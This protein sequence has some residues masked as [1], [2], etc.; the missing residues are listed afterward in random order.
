MEL[1][2]ALQALAQVDNRK[3]RV[4]EL[5]FFGG[6]SVDE[7]AEALGSLR[8]RSTVTGDWRSRGF[9]ASSEGGRQMDPERWS[10]IDRIYHEAASLTM[11]SAGVPYRDVRR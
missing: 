7:A 6:F 4:V 1:D 10:R 2:L 9:A 11:R 3:S 5:R 8:R